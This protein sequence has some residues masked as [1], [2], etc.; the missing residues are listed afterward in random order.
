MQAAEWRRKQILGALRRLGGRVDDDRGRA[1]ALLLEA[2]GRPFGQEA[3]RQYLKALER[4]GLIGRDVADRSCTAIYLV[5]RAKPSR[6]NGRPRGPRI[7][8]AEPSGDRPWR[9]AYRDDHD[10]RRYRQFPEE[11]LALA[12]MAQ[13]RVEFGES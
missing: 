2:M 12:F 10:V 6:P 1:T 3:L 9:V 7:T 5:E 13:K 4:D 11:S 8:L